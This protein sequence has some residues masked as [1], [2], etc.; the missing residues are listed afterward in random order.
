[1]AI[2]VRLAE[3]QLQGENPPQASAA[4]LQPISRG[5]EA[6]SQMLLPGNSGAPG[7]SGKPSTARH[8]TP[9]AD[10]LGSRLSGW[11]C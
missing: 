4:A 9:L 3:D 2:R 7:C 10:G 6:G 11:A 5:G 1:M 8:N